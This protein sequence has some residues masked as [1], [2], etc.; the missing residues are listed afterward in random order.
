[1]RFLLWGS[2]CRG[3]QR[4]SRQCPQFWGLG[5]AAKDGGAGKSGDKCVFPLKESKGCKNEGGTATWQAAPV[6]LSL[7]AAQRA[8]WKAVTPLIVPQNSA[9]SLRSGVRRK[10]KGEAVTAEAGQAQKKRQGSFFL[11]VKRSRCTWPRDKELVLGW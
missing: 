11:Q 6:L 10:G 2:T 1:M 3:K 8:V 4:L 7:P 5:V 9:W